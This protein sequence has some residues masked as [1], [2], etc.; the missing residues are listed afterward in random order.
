MHK[1]N[2]LWHTFTLHHDG[3]IWCRAAYTFCRRLFWQICITICLNA[4]IFLIFCIFVDF[5]VVLS[6]PQSNLFKMVKKNCRT[7]NQL[8]WYSLIC[9]LFIYIFFLFSYAII[10]SAHKRIQNILW[11]FILFFVVFFFLNVR[12]EKKSKKTEIQTTNDNLDDLRHSARM[13]NVS[14]NKILIKKKKKEKKKS[15]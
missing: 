3:I 7:R 9:C 15:V 10:L 11:I 4:I 13:K 5:V 6:I 14:T 2:W 1:I 12:N 8:F